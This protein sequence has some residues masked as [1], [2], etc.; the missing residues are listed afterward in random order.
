[1]FFNGGSLG[2]ELDSCFL[3]LRL[4]GKRV[5][6]LVVSKLGND[7]LGLDTTVDCK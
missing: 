2:V 6:V 3:E 7:K 1:M 4:A 5:D